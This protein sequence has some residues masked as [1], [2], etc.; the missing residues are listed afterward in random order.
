MLQYSKAFMIT[1][2]KSAGTRSQRGNR[3]LHIDAMRGIAAL[4][5]VYFH[6][7]WELPGTGIYLSRVEAAL[8]FWTSNIFD[9]GKIAVLVFFAISGYFIPFSLIK[10]SS[11][12]ASRIDF[13]VGRFFRLYPAYWLSVIAAVIVLFH[14]ENNPISIITVLSNLTMLQGFIRQPDLI[15]TYWTLQIELIF[16]AL[17]LGLQLLGW[18]ERPKAVAALIGFFLSVAILMAGA[19][20]TTGIKLPVAVPMAL[21]I[22]LFGMLWRFSSIGRADFSKKIVYGLLAVIGLASLIVSVLAYSHDY[23]FHETWYRYALSYG[24]AL[25]LFV[26]FSTVV[27]TR[28]PVLAYLG[29]ISFS[30]YL[31]GP[32][33]Q[34]GIAYAVPALL[35]GAWPAYLF[36]LIVLCGTIMVASA[37][38]HLIEA[39]SIRMGKK[40][41]LRLTHRSQVPTSVPFEA[42]L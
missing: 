34:H 17:C 31:F 19:R 12:R 5:V 32:I 30:I 3:Y 4:A 21:S 41:A 7:A 20:Y 25:F 38:Y 40:V 24:T 35:S 8:F 10:D 36:V 13:I 27:W 18:L 28:S 14:L 39:P 23:G 15:G 1:N 42:P 29:K 37:V 26:V 22:M 6:M 9:F 33:T 2:E 11:A 16:Y